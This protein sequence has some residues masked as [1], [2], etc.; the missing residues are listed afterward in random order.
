[1][2]SRSADNRG[3]AASSPIVGH[4]FG[5]GARVL[6]AAATRRGRTA[7]AG[8]GFR[9]QREGSRQAP[10]LRA[11]RAHGR[12]AG[13]VQWRHQRRRP[14]AASSF[15]SSTRVAPKNSS[16]PRSPWPGGGSGPVAWPRVA[17]TRGVIGESAGGASRAPRPR[18]EAVA[19]E[20]PHERCAAGPSAA[21]TTSRRGVLAWQAKPSQRW[22][23]VCRRVEP[24]VWSPSG[25]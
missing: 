10:P 22:A 3:R 17:V 23:S 2:R 16:A 8:E 5:G 21:A 18:C 1:M 4:R 14:R 6:F 20:G 7:A 19:L 25:G 15:A 11:G 13:T 12:S 9:R 24:T